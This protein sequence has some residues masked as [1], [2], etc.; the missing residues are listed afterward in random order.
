MSKKISELMKGT[1][2]DPR[3][4]NLLSKLNLTVEST[5]DELHNVVEKLSNDT[6]KLE[7]LFQLSQYLVQSK[8]SDSGASK[9]NNET[10]LTIEELDE[11]YRRL[12]SAKSDIVVVTRRAIANINYPEEVMRD[13]VRQKIL[14]SFAIS[15]ER[16]QGIYRIVKKIYIGEVYHYPEI[17]ELVEEIVNDILYETY[18]GDETK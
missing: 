18:F 1:S 3:V 14:T 15:I 9:E 4:L 17:Y 11:V 5:L 12:L 13:Y 7:I 8:R 2:L 10:S 16:K 6:D